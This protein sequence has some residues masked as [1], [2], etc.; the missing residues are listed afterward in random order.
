M[1]GSCESSSV[2][3]SPAPYG[4][5]SRSSEPSSS[6]GTSWPRIQA[7]SRTTGIMEYCRLVRHK[8]HFARVGVMAIHCSIQGMQPIQARHL[9]QAAAGRWAVEKQIE[10][11]KIPS[12]VSFADGA[13]GIWEIDPEDSASALGS[14][15][16]FLS[17]SRMSSAF[18]LFLLELG[19]FKFPAWRFWATMIFLL[20]LQNCDPKVYFIR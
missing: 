4:I 6:I 20:V 8:G 17:S 11:R 7:R 15:I 3:W 14:A 5:V 2:S 10:Q 18:P 13:S 16:I 12:R 19:C 9:E 1:W